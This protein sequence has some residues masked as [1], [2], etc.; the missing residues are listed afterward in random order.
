MLWLRLSLNCNL[1][2]NLSREVEMSQLVKCK[3]IRLNLQLYIPIDNK[4]IMWQTYVSSIIEHEEKIRK[5]CLLY[6]MLTETN[7]STANHCVRKRI[8]SIL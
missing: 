5:Q 2:K 6:K 1:G 3:N 7:Y 8:L 4:D